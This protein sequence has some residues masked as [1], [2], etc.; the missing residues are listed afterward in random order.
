M[1]AEPGELSPWLVACHSCMCAMITCTYS[2]ILYTIP[3][4]TSQTTWSDGATAADVWNVGEALVRMTKIPNQ[5]KL[6][7]KT[8]GMHL[9]VHSS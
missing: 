2:L 4:V 9:H 5:P 3:T 1:G 6:A 8:T 7:W